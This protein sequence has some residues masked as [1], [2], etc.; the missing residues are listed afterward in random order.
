MK[1]EGLE[2]ALIGKT[3]KLC[4]ITKDRAGK[5]HSILFGFDSGEDMSIGFSND[6]L[7]FWHN[8]DIQPPKVG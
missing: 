4:E 2:A 5:N 8:N 7:F 3:I 1:T 6:S